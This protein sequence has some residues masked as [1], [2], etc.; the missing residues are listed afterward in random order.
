M[1]VPLVNGNWNRRTN[2]ENR[3]RTN[4]L[5]ITCLRERPPLQF[6]SIYWKSIFPC[7]LT[8]C[9]KI[10][11]VPWTNLPCAIQVNKP[12]P[13]LHLT[14]PRADYAQI[15]TRLMFLYQSLVKSHVL[16]TGNI[17]PSFHY[18]SLPV[19]HHCSTILILSPQRALKNRR[20]QRIMHLWISKRSL[21]LT[22]CIARGCYSIYTWFSMAETT[23][24]ILIRFGT[25]FWCLV[26]MQ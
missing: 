14:Q 19:I 8:F 2:S 15:L 9:L 5:I 25:R 21:M 16:L 3:S 7:H 17:L 24:L 1:F 10:M 20:F 13:K 6:I 11:E 18:C 4:F 22:N 26:T 12:L 23:K